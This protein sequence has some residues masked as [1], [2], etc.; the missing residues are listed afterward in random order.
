MCLLPILTFSISFLRSGDSSGTRLTCKTGNEATWL[1]C[2][3]RARVGLVSC[4][5]H[6]RRGL[7]TRLGQGARPRVIPRGVP[8]PR[9]ITSYPR[10]HKLGGYRRRAKKNILR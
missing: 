10:G 7:G 9:Y 3:S 4:P 2:V 6:P 8:S 5:D 1:T